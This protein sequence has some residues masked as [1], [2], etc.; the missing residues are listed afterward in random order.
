MRLDTETVGFPDLFLYVRPRF[1]G[2]ILLGRWRFPFR[3]LVFDDER[4]G[5]AGTV[6]VCSPFIT[7]E[8]IHYANK[9]VHSSYPFNLILQLDPFR[10]TWHIVR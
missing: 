1:S 8:K 6:R 10:M 4:V 9:L 7:W 3:E 2:V 5:V